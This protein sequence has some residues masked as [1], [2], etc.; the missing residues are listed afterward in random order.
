MSAWSPKHAILPAITLSACLLFLIFRVAFVSAPKP[1]KTD[2]ATSLVEEFQITGINAQFPPSIQ[3]WEREICIAARKNDL[4]PNLIAA[5]IHQES[6]G[7]PSIISSSGAVGVMQIMPHDG[8]ASTFLCING[9]CFQDRPSTEELKDP[10]FNI[11]YGGNLLANLIARQGSLRSALRSYGPMD[12][13]FSYADK[14]LSIYQT[15]Q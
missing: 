14:V 15:Y 8:K 13:G 12:V 1:N 11:A 6:G 9:P 3:K 2:D 5:V 7:Q 10:M 4:D